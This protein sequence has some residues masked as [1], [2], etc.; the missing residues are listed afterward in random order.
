M[1][2]KYLSICVCLCLL[3]S[4]MPSGEAFLWQRDDDEA[5]ITYSRDDDN[6]MDR[7]Y[8]TDAANGTRLIPTWV[9]YYGENGLSTM[10]L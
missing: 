8:E 3:E 2:S 9:V 1:M 7:Y 10:Y 6:D 4:L 5:G